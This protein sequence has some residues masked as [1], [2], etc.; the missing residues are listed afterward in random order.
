MINLDLLDIWREIHPEMDYE[1]WR[2]NTPLQQS[3]LD[4]FFQI[5]DLLSSYMT[6]ADIKPGYRTDHSM[7]T[8]TF[9][10]GRLETR[11]QLLWKFNSS[12]WN[13]KL[14]ANKNRDW[15][16]CSSTLFSWKFPFIPKCDIQFVISDQLVL[17]KNS[18]EN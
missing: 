15:R 4:F 11:N 12:L 5:S 13:N 10:L 6:E 3:R 18:Y 1:I 2:R 16:I 8:L 17:E 7:T 14:F 9:T